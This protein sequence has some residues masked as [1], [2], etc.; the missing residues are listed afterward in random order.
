MTRPLLVIFLTI[1]VNLIGFG[2]IIPLLPFYAETFGAS[3][4]V[5]G[6]LFAA[7]SHLSAGRRA[8]ARRLV[9]SIRAPARPDLQ[10]ARH[11][12]QLRDAGG[13]ALGR[14]AVPREDRGRAVRGQYFDGSRVR[15]RR[16]RAERPRARLRA[17][18]R[19][20]RAGF[21]FRSRTERC[22]RQGQLHRADLGRGGAHA[23]RDRGRL[24][25]A[26]GN[27]SSRA[28]R[29]RF[30]PFARCPACCGGRGSAASS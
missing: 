22:A 23:C 4:L 10:S 30:C 29:H 17:H 20:V 8:R 14:D 21:H 19:R 13:G 18:R 9:R 15:R 11:R 5:I 3:P 28:G 27:G 7:F 25:L 16:D 1:F 12:R 2:I 6:L 26:A 24:A